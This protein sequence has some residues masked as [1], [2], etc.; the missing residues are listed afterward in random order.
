MARCSSRLTV[1]PSDWSCPAVWPLARVIMLLWDQELLRRLD[2]AA[3]NTRWDLFAYL[4]YIDDGNMAANEVP[5]GTRYVRGKLGQSLW[6]KT[7]QNL[8]IKAQLRLSRRLLIPSSN[9]SKWRLI[10]LP[11]NLRMWSPAWT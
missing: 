9:S 10:T 6:R 4:R 1:A 7:E 5:L 8:E 2:K 11:S 3:E